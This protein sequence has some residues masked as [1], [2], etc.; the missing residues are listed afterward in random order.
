NVTLTNIPD[1]A[2][3]KDSEGNEIS[4]NN[5]GSYSI[6][7][8]EDGKTNITLESN[9]KLEE[10]ELNDI[11]VSATASESYGGSEATTTISHGGET[12]LDI[13]ASE[14]ESIDLS[15]IV[16]G[17]NNVTKVDFTDNQTQDIEIDLDD[18]LADNSELIIKGDYEDKVDLDD[19]SGSW[20]K[21]DS[22]EEVDG[23]SYTVYNGTSN[24]STVKILIDENI[25]VNPDI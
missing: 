23:D 9:V 13:D 7:V 17:H 3:F 5:D 14:N 22:K 12:V 1:N 2:I 11:S 8:D 25:D 20:E 18:I 15:D 19:G 24:N 16:A 4:S 10:N 6:E 21:S